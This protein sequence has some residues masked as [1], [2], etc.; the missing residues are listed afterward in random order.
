MNNISVQSLWRNAKNKLSENKRA[1]EVKI[2]GINNEEKKQF[3]QIKVGKNKNLFHRLEC[4]PDLKNR[5]IQNP[6]WQYFTFY[7]IKPQIL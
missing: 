3:K 2:F 1:K 5:T 4:V 7:V 6:R